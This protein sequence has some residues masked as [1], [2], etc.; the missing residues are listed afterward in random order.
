MPLQR[1]DREAPASRLADWL[2]LLALSQRERPVGG[3]E[4]QKIVRIEAEDR[5][6]RL[7]RDALSED[8][9]EGEIV[10]RENEQIV[11]DVFDEIGRRAALLGE[12]IGRA[13]V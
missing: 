3:G 2:E 1:P 10:A 5:S 7:V 13:H 12:K 6:S 8:I 4:L 9:E 11:S